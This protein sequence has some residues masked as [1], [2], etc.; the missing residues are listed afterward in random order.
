MAVHHNAIE[1]EQ[2]SDHKVLSLWN[3]NSNQTQKERTGEKKDTSLGR[4]FQPGGRGGFFHY[5]F[6]LISKIIE[7]WPTSPALP[8]PF[9]E[10]NHQPLWGNL[11]RAR[12]TPLRLQVAQKQL[13][14]RSTQQ[15]WGHMLACLHSTVQERKLFLGR[16]QPNKVSA[17]LECLFTADMQL[18]AKRYKKIP[19]ELRSPAKNIAMSLAIY[20]YPFSVNKESIYTKN[21][22]FFLNLILQSYCRQ[23]S[24]L[25]KSTGLGPCY[26]LYFV[27]SHHPEAS[28]F[29]TGSA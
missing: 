11:V 29:E 24:S 7:T 19:F 15:N 20:P 27:P 25:S 28:I 18:L 22:F 12:I 4:R 10:T 9:L 6:C 16:K 8:Q 17:R 13:L 5:Y 3:S 2:Y 21:N 23:N 14:E 26:D 1:M